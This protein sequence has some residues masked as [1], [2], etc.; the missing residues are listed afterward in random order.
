MK[1]LNPR[2]LVA[3]SILSLGVGCSGL[4]VSVPRAKP[5]PTVGARF[6]G[7]GV[8]KSTGQ[9]YQI[10]V[11]GGDEHSFAPKVAKQPAREPVRPNVV[12]VGGGLAGLT[13][14]VY[15]TDHGS[16]VVLIEKEGHLGGL[17]AGGNTING[18]SY[19]RGAAY[20]TAAYHEE[21][22]IL[23]H[24][25]MAR[26]KK[27]H[28]IPEPIDTYLLRGVIYGEEPFEGM[29]D[30]RTLGNVPSEGNHPILPVSFAIFKAE[31]KQADKK[32]QIPNQPF[33]EAS[34]LELDHL[35]AAS[36]IRSMPEMLKKRSNGP[37]GADA[38]RLLARLDAEIA[39]GRIDRRDPMKDV[40]E[41][42]EVYCRSALG[43]TPDQISGVAF[44]NFYISEI[45][46]RYTSDV[47][48]G[49]VAEKME[50]ILR[51]RPGLARILTHTSVGAITDK[52]GSVEV[53]YIVNGETRQIE[54]DHVVF[55]AQLGMAPKLIRDFSKKAPEQAKL[56][57]GLKYSHYSVHGVE[58]TGDPYR[59]SYDTWVHD[60][61]HDP[62]R[63]SDLIV[64]R[65]MEPEYRKRPLDMNDPVGAV[66]S[67]YNPL[68]TKATGSYS[69]ARATQLAEVAVN[70]MDALFKEHFRHPL[71]IKRVV[72]SRWPYSVHVAE[73]GHYRLKARTLRKPFGRIY[74]ANN[75]IGT[76]AFEEALFRGHCAANN[77]LLKTRP[78]FKFE[79]W[80]QC[81]VE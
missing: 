44:A 51:S 61:K 48:T 46:T 3:L 13:A 75:N 5:D 81:P 29:W 68:S 12:I 39:S 77:I 28:P 19:D 70:Q 74:F 16:S 31:L 26:Y 40:V 41:L 7:T 24:I 79:T 35:D 45:E 37:E 42:M 17:A 18:V 1:I 9:R 47:G 25:G 34:N 53:S 69:E 58:V 56:M 60:P 49:K 63:F 4:P 21:Y 33:E 6:D 10:L 27:E 62:S 59:A 54:A 57:A 73:P 23:K 78:G 15:L 55:A 66:L 32:G 2:R 14:G 71:N 64:G 38:R 67:I 8:L 50:A 52:G 72:T 22:E 20:W 36:W 80:T 11:H 43:A 30:E 76:P 65:W